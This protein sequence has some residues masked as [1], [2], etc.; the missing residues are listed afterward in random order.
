MK[1]TLI[2]AFLAIALSTNLAFAGEGTNSGGGG[3]DIVAEFVIRATSLLERVA[4]TNP[5]IKE[6]AVL[7]ALLKGTSLRIIP[8]SKLK[9][10]ISGSEIPD[11]AGLLAYGM[12]GIIQLK[13][14][15]WDKAFSSGKN[16]DQHIYHE[17]CRAAAPKCN[18]EA[19]RISIVELK[20]APTSYISSVAAATASNADQLMKLSIENSDEDGIKKALSMGL[21]LNDVFR[22]HGGT[23]FMSHEMLLP[24]AYAAL[25]GNVKSLE[26]LLALGAGVNDVDTFHMSALHRAAA[27]NRVA[28]IRFLVSKGADVDVAAEWGLGHPNQPSALMATIPSSAT[29]AAKVLLDLGASLDYAKGRNTDQINSPLGAA[30]ESENLTMVKL[31]ISHGA[32]VHQGFWGCWVPLHCAANKGNI[33]LA[34]LLLDNGADVNFVDKDEYFGVTALV[35]A[36]DAA[37]TK[38]LLENGADAKFVAEDGQTP[39]HDAA[40]DGDI[41]KMKVLLKAGAKLNSKWTGN[42]SYP[43]ITPLDATLIKK[44]KD[45]YKFLRSIGAK[46]SSELK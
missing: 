33:A 20:L 3:S 43:N 40:F 28:A 25:I 2:T 44:H 6:T 21:K 13:T 22:T 11:Q 41:A 36:K 38:F 24:L 23:R 31:F 5:E 10:M 19:Y 42:D 26:I 8:V 45:A 18:D 15:V 7:K 1:N 32:D 46:R 16:M 27:F 17:L 9:D 37:V 30:V 35:L 4:V 14:E 34:K 12:P 39:M 29:E